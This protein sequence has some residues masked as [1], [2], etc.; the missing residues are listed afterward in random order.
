MWREIFRMWFD[1]IYYTLLFRSSRGV[2]LHVEEVSVLMV[3]MHELERIA[4]I[5]QPRQTGSVL[6]DHE[7]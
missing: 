6:G 1:F 2:L 7:P 3:G 4:P 5:V